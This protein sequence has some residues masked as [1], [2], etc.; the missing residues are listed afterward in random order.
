MA[1]TSKETNKH[2]RKE[3]EYHQIKES[4]DRQKQVIRQLKDKEKL[5]EEILEETH[6][7]EEK[8]EKKANQ[9]QRI[10][11]TMRDLK[12]NNRILRS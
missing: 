2:S 8:E 12:E 5:L 11:E 9:E 4:C 1:K 3:K 7:S 6:S 10:I